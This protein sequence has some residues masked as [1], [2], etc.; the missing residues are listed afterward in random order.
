MEGKISI[1]IA[2]E[3]RAQAGATAEILQ[4]QGYEVGVA[5]GES[6]CLARM[7]QDYF[8]LLLLPDSLP[9][10]GYFN[11]LLQVSANFP[12]TIMI[13]LAARP[14]IA[15]AVEAMRLGAFD[16]LPDPSSAEELLASINDAL[17]YRRMRHESKRL[18]S[19]QTQKY[20]VESIVG[21]SGPMQAVFKLIHKVAATDATVLVLGESGTGKELVARAIHH[22]SARSA[23]PMIPVNCGAIPEDLLESELFGHEKGAFTGAIKS[24]PG[25]FELASGGTIFLD[26]IGDMSPALQVKIL[27]VLQ[28]HQFERV[29]GART[30]NAD[31]RVI[32][33]THR[34]LRQ[35]VEDGSFREDLYYRL[36]VI[37]INI[38]PLRERRG[39]IALLSQHFLSRL[40][41]LK[42]LEKKQL[43]PQVL[44]A[45]M[46]YQWPGNVRELENLLER[47]VILA[48]GPV[49]QV[50]DLPP[51]LQEI[52]AAPPLKGSPLELPDEGLDFNAAVDEFERNLIVQALEKTGWVKNQAASLLGLN[53][54]TLVEKIKKK[55][56]IE[57][58]ASVA[59]N[60]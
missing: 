6:A 31:I 51:K 16:Y 58:E 25:R 40:S 12:E 35:K 55:G 1:L 11:L 26:E 2:D 53:R 24:K 23:K 59:A 56:L 18:R 30:I 3:R 20:D 32:A 52:K 36:N 48:S 38:P 5:E 8:D 43:H 29:G 57:P 42:R 14:D 15:G 33:A 21:Q 46:R 41:D 28:E 17:E 19:A 39:D 9:G 60:K 49:L 54:T 22:H 4:S 10:D 34:D 44:E 50:E 45:L 37:P 13:C 47:M 7:E 27:R